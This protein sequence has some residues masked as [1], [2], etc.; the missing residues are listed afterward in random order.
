[1]SLLR[2]ARDSC[3]SAA[4]FAERFRETAD[5]TEEIVD[6]VSDLQFTSRYRVPFQFSRFVRERFKAARSCRPLWRNR[7]DLDGNQFFD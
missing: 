5:L 1:M 3:A 2:A 4:V 6:G 7:H